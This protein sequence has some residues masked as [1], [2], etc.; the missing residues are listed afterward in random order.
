MHPARIVALACYAGL[1]LLVVVWEV[2]LAPAI[3]VPRLFWLILKLTPLALP[4]PGLIKQSAK[5]YVYAALVT[6]LY[7]VEGVV[8][9][10]SAW[11]G[12]EAEGAL[13]YALL[14]TALASGFFVSAAYYARFISSATTH[15][16]RE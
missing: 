11:T 13:P 3:V 6:L 12:T 4:L 16:A 9:A 15:P 8:V 1:I 2:W 10:Y 5:A 7:F 14:E